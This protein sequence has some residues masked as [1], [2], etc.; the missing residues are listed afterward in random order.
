MNLNI[1]IEK[2]P[3]GGYILK[4]GDN[5]E[6]ATSTAPE[7]YEHIGAMMRDAFGENVAKHWEIPRQQAPSIPVQR[8]PSR[9]EEAVS[10]VREK[11]NGSSLS[12]LNER[13]PQVAA[14]AM[15][16]LLAVNVGW[17]FGA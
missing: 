6:T 10:A 2:A 8:Q 14:A 17:P 3:K 1:Q 7:L 5:L 15:A 16:F 9:T 11:L 13:I 4:N 12:S